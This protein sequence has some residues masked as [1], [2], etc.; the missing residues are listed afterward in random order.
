M[1]FNEDDTHKLQ[2]KWEQWGSGVELVVLPSPYRSLR[3]PLLRY[4]DRL[5][6]KGS[7]DFVTVVLPEFIPA[8]W[9]QHFLHN[10]SSLLLKGAL[11]FKKCVVVVSVPYHLES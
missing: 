8:R 2:E 4:I 11:L 6:R 3:R 10:Q 1:D 5:R 9:W 7:D